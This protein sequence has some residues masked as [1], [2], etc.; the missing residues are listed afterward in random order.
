MRPILNHVFRRSI[1]FTG[2]N[3]KLQDLKKKGKKFEK[4]KKLTKKKLEKEKRI[5]KKKLE[6][7][8]SKEKISQMNKL[9]KVKKSVEE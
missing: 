8:N 5:D 4:E 1:L 2:I 3:P 6:K 9:V 7:K